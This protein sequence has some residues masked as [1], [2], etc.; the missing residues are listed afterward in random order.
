MSSKSN[1]KPFLWNL[2]KRDTRI[3]CWNAAGKGNLMESVRNTNEEEAERKYHHL[4]INLFTF[5]LHPPFDCENNER[6][7]YTRVDLDEK[8]STPT[9]RDTISNPPEDIWKQENLN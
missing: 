4:L 7:E 8:E 9:E 1:T 2:L 3:G 5:H 6:L